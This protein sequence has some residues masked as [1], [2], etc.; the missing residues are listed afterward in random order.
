MNERNF[1]QQIRDL[2]KNGHFDPPVGGEE[3][4][5]FGTQPYGNDVSSQNPEVTNPSFKDRFVLS[6]GALRVK[7]TYTINEDGKKL[8]VTIVDTEGE[9]V[10]KG[11]IL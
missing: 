10:N 2:S 1:G 6:A 3:T 8:R 5:P 7:R 9:L 4:R 11:P